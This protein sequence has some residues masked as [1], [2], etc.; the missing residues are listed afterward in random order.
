MNY[1]IENEEICLLSL[2]KLRLKS[3][4][5]FHRCGSSLQHICAGSQQVH[6]EVQ[7]TTPLHPQTTDMCATDS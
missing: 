5:Y 1:T 6:M 4:S 2:E 3:R 7:E